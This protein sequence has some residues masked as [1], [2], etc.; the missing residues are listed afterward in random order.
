MGHVMRTTVSCPL[1]SVVSYF[2]LI[3]VEIERTRERFSWFI[4][5]QTVRTGTDRKGRYGNEYHEGERPYGK[6]RGRGSGVQ[7]RMKIWVE[8]T[9]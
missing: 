9:D 5:C 8:S 6:G 3:N 1:L 7:L 4:S 2:R